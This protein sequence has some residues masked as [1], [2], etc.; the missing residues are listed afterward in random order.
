MAKSLSHQPVLLPIIGA[1]LGKIS[2][3]AAVLLLAL[4]L[5]VPPQVMFGQ[6]NQQQEQ[7]HREQQEREH[8]QRDQHRE[9]SSKENSRNEIGNNGNSNRES[10][11]RESSRNASNNSAI[12]NSEISNDTIPVIPPQRARTRVRRNFAS[13]KAACD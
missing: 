3:A 5:G 10:S 1:I 11:S 4:A 7:Q 6:S 12:S 2:K 8:Q 9:N 13:S